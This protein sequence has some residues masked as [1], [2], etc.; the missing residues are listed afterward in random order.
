[1][2]LAFTNT[3]VIS[4]K[5]IFYSIKKVSKLQFNVTDGYKMKVTKY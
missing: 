2:T 3:E 5:S 4:K 1:M